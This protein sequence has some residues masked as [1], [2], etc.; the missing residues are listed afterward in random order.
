MVIADQPL[1]WTPVQQRAALC[2]AGVLMPPGRT[3]PVAIARSLGLDIDTVKLW[4]NHPDFIARVDQLIKATAE[5]IMEAGLA[6]KAARV[7]ELQK[8]H[9]MLTSIL[10]ARE[11]WAAVHAENDIV[12]D[13]LTDSGN[14]FIIPGVGTGA[15]RLYHKAV[16]SGPSQQIVVEGEFDTALF[17]ELRAIETQL[18]RELGQLNPQTSV[19]INMKMYSNI[20]VTSV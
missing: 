4:R 20:D 18:A 7:L 12:A 2:F 13:E 11:E 16:G 6:L 14:T 19:S 17:A 1:E 3:S 5:E 9:A 15:L 10:E 8:R